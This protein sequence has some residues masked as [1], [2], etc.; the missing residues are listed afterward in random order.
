MRARDCVRI[1]LNDHR[2]HALDSRLTPPFRNLVLTPGTG[3]G[4]TEA[5]LLPIFGPSG[6]GGQSGRF[7]LEDAQCG[8]LLLYPMN[9]LVNDQLGRL[10]CASSATTTSHAGS[11]DQRRA[12]PMKFARYTWGGPCTQVAARRTQRR[13]D[14]ALKEPPRRSSRKLEIA[15]LVICRRETLI[16]E[17]RHACG[18]VAGRS[19]RPVPDC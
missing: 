11:T 6:G 19:H 8:R 3:S 18:K 7:V 1:R 12:H 13:L 15:Q 17:L 16:G 5:F 4:K 9:A 2:A 14:S 10:R